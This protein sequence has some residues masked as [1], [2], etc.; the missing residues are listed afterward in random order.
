MHPPFSHLAFPGPDRG[1]PPNRINTN[2]LS[3]HRRPALLP[4]PATPVHRAI[5]ISRSVAD[6]QRH[7]ISTRPVLFSADAASR[8]LVARSNL[9]N[10]V[11]ITKTCHPDAIKTSSS[12]RHRQSCNQQKQPKKGAFPSRSPRHSPLVAAITCEHPPGKQ[13]TLTALH[14]WTLCDQGRALPV[15][16]R[17]G[18][19]HKQV[20][21]AVEIFG[22]ALTFCPSLPS[23]ARSV[24]S[25]RLSRLSLLSEFSFGRLR[26]IRP[27]LPKPRHPCACHHLGQEE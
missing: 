25:P 20:A 4:S 7:V 5:S 27:S 24:S 6:S 8:C 13:S 26:R 19:S 14:H 17:R 9:P 21:S 22:V 15:L 11:T 16:D 3:P 12:N 2:N 1:S 23:S 10:L 18:R